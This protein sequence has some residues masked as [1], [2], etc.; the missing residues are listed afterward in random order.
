M[1]DPFS[2]Y[3]GAWGEFLLDRGSQETC[4]R[5]REGDSFHKAAKNKFTPVTARMIRTCSY[6]L[7]NHLHGKLLIKMMT[8]RVWHLSS[9][10]FDLG[11]LPSV[12]KSSSTWLACHFNY[13]EGRGPLCLLIVE[14]QRPIF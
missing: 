11:K 6:M 10:T 1:H 14:Y 2:V 9:F 3:S 13:F 12:T 4:F 8:F 7:N 5:E